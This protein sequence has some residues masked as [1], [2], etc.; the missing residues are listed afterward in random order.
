MA[1]LR[2][3]DERV[4]IS[5]ECEAATNNRSCRRC[6]ENGKIVGD[7]EDMDERERR[8]FDDAF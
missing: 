1:R 4:N 7:S 3:E 2:E 8:E 6:R 5:M